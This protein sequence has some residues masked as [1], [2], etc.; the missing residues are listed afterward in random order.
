MEEK[1]RLY[2][3]YTM[4]YLEVEYINGVSTIRVPGGWVID[5]TFV[6]FNNEKQEYAFSP[7]DKRIR[8]RCEADILKTNYP[9]FMNKP[10][11]EKCG[12]EFEDFQKGV[13]QCPKCRGEF[14]YK[15][16]SHKRMVL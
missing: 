13:Y 1:E 16:K 9:D 7:T 6:P 15:S 2:I 3:L 12:H 5:N 11:F 14:K 8:L 10:I 4:E